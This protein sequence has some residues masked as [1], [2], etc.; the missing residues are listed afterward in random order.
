LPGFRNYL[1]EFL[2][3]IKHPN[4]NLEPSGVCHEKELPEGANMKPPRGFLFPLGGTFLALGM[5]SE[6]MHSGKFT[7]YE[8]SLGK[9]RVITAL[10]F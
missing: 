5:I 6:N 4:L 7:L 2:F 8:E 1:N 3:S 10:P 9:G